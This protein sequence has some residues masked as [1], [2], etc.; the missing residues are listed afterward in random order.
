MKSSAL[1]YDKLYRETITEIEGKAGSRSLGREY[2]IGVA[3]AG[4]RGSVD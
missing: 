1:D 2:K 4:W 3:S